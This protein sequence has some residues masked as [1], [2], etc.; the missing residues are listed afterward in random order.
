MISNQDKCVEAFIDYSKQENTKYQCDL[1]I[2]NQDG[3]SPLCLALKQGIDELVP[4]LVQGGCD[5]NV[6]NS[7]DLTL[8]HQAI[9]K[10]DSKT[11]LFLLENGADID[12]T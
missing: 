12:A 11:A 5:V 3:D 6:R 9:L 1:N 7:N 8:L 2:K 10:E 4:I